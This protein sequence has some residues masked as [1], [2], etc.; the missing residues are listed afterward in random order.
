MLLIFEYS[1]I[2]DIVSHNHIEY[3]L[4]WHIH[5]YRLP[6]VSVSYVLLKFSKCELIFEVAQSLSFSD[7]GIKGDTIEQMHYLPH[8]GGQSL[9][10]AIHSEQHPLVATILYYGTPLVID[11]QEL[12]KIKWPVLGVIWR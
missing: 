4:A 11:K 5:A 3:I 12:S 9:P 1:G 2:C 10:L 8:Y 6:A 7:H